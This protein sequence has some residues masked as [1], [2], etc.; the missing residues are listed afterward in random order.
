MINFIARSNGGN[1]NP[2]RTQYQNLNDNDIADSFDG[3]P[4][5][6]GNDNY[7]GGY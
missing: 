4:T 1:T 5:A 3:A 7:Q 2:F 6:V